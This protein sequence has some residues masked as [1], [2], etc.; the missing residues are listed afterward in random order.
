VDSIREICS[1]IGLIA[2]LVYTVMT[3]LPTATSWDEYEITDWHFQSVT[4]EDWTTHKDTLQWNS[5]EG[6]S[7][8]SSAG[9][10]IAVGKY[11]CQIKLHNDQPLDEPMSV[12]LGGLYG[13]A[14]VWLMVNIVMSS[15]VLLSVSTLTQ[16]KKA[17][18][19]EAMEVPDLSLEKWWKVMRFVVVAMIGVLVL[20]CML[21]INAVSDTYYIKWPQPW[22]KNLCVD[23][24]WVPV[25]CSVEAME[26]GNCDADG[27]YEV[28]ETESFEVFARKYVNGSFVE[29]HTNF[30]R[31]GGK[32][33]VYGGITT[34]I[35]NL[36]PAQASGKGIVKMMIFTVLT[37]VAAG[38]AQKL[39]DDKVQ[40]E[41][42]KMDKK[43]VDEESVAG[44][45]K[46]STKDGFGFGPTTLQ[47]Y[48]EAGSGEGGAAN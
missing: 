6:R 36:D 41:W 48:D 31:K 11:G 22:L 2:A 23:Q 39:A 40:K 29:W 34:S 18:D 19:S 21:S 7:M 10:G 1:L 3:A 33:M 46:A 30:D 45:N 5:D 9:T 25:P 20:G 24:G 26:A 35:K 27:I 15:L 44:L 4:A 38:Y 8:Q 47:P 42:K 14:T 17:G 28:F 37:V 13:R 43:V 16:L 32:D 12:Y